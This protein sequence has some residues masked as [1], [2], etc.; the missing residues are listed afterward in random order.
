MRNYQL[1]YLGEVDGAASNKEVRLFN[2]SP[3]YALR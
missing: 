2:N 3:T 1:A